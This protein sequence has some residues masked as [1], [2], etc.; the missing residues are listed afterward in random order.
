MTERQ[1]RTVLEG[2]SYFEGPR[3]HDGEWWVSDFYRHTVSRVPASGGTETVVL[4]VENQPSGLGWLPDGA[5]LVVSMK[6]HRLL[7]VLD[8]DV[9]THADLSDVCGGYLNDMVVDASG[10]A[11]VG[12]FGFDL[13]GGGAPA[14]ASVKRVDP[15]GTVTVVADGLH[16]PNGS[17]ITP[18]GGTLIVGETW[19]NRYTAFTIGA[20]GALTD[21]R[22]WASFGPLPAGTAI[23]ELIPQVVLGPDGCTLDADG[24]I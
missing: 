4:E 18:D 19:G 17:V 16:F 13:M 3:W 15:D 7:R 21:R 10:R 24:H 20:D 12:D 23:P 11:Y 8:G 2:G 6:D 14:S 9:S 22:I 5:L 1:F